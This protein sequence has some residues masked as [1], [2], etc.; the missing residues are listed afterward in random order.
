MAD[1]RTVLVA[2]VSGFAGACIMA[3]GNAFGFSGRLTKVETTIEDIR[4][5][6][7]TLVTRI[8]CEK[9]I[10]TV[11]KVFNLQLKQHTQRIQELKKAQDKGFEN[12]SGKLDMILANGNGGLK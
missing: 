8:D 2:G 12:M 3:V 11:E 1:G 6:K 9:S 4:K 5:C 7:T 10:L